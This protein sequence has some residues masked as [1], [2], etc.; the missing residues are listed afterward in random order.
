MPINSQDDLSAALS[1]EQTWV[2]SK[3]KNIHSVAAQAAGVWYDLSKGAGIIPIDAVI[4]SASNLT[5]Q[6]VSDNT[7][8]TA[9]TAALGGSIAGTTFTD[10][11]HATGRFTV[12]MLLSGAGVLPGTYITALGTGSGANNG[13]TYTVNLGQTVTA[14]TI[15]GT[16]VSAFFQHGG[17]VAPAVKQLLNASVV[18]AAATSAP[19]FFQLIDIIGFITVST[20]T[21]NNAQAVIGPMVYPRYANGKGVKAF[22]TPIV[23]MGAG[24]P[25]IQLGYTNPAGVS[26]RL[27]PPSPSLPIANNAAPAGQILYSGT[28]VGKYGPSMPLQGGD[29]GILSLQTIQLSGSMTSGVFVIVLYKEIGLPLPLTTQGV[30]AERDYFNQQ[31]SMPIIPDGACLSWLMLAG[32]ATPVNTPYNMTIQTVWK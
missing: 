23:A 19:A 14:Q 18:S 12:G 20:V 4:G 30:P 8:T 28:G 22:I 25:S 31:P 9:A 3:S 26:G 1:A 15:T 2:E 6:P 24:T 10:T 32:A 11:T 17:N 13:G 21:I 27:T 16:A 7:T 5:F 29:N